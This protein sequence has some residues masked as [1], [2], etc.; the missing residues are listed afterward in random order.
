MK[1]TILVF[2]F[3]F[4]SLGC[5]KS[6][7]SKPTERLFPPSEQSKV[8]GKGSCF[9]GNYHA[10]VYN[11]SSWTITRIIL[12]IAGVGYEGQNMEEKILWTR[13]FCAYPI[14]SRIR[15]LTTE[16]C[17]IQLPDI[18]HN[19]QEPLRIKEIYGYKQ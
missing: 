2:F 16:T 1:N 3:F 9:Q 17:I 6:Q 8:S 19:A 7:N 14:M 4:L 12:I 5:G 10:E 18:C 11:G 15:P 13:D